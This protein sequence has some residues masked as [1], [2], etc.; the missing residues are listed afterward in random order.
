M[1]DITIIGAGI[2]GVNVALAL[3][4]KGFDTLIVDQ[5]EPA[6]GCSSG[7]A[8]VIASYGVTP[9]SMPGLWKQV[10]NML[11]KPDGPLSIR[12]QH[13]LRL[14]PW[15]Y[16]FW[17]CARP[18][19]VQRNSVAL[20]QLVQHG[21]QDYLQITQAAGI[22]HLLKPSPVLAVYGSQA[23]FE[24]DHQVWRLRQEQGVR[25]ETIQ[26]EALHDLEPALSDKLNFAV[27]LQN[28][29]FVVDPQLFTQALFN[30]YINKGGR[31]QR[32]KV[33]AL[34]PDE[35]GVTLVT[36]TDPLKAKQV[37]V[38]CGAFSA[39]LAQGLG[40]KIPLEQERG[41]HITLSDF[42]GLPPRH[43]IISPA[44]KVIATPMQPGLR[45]AGMVEFGGFLPPNFKRSLILHQ[46]LLALFPT[47]E[48]GSYTQ[49]MGHRPTLPDSV[50]VI[51]R[52]AASANI[53]YAFGH[54]HVGLTSGPM[55]ARLITEMIEGVE[56]T[57]DITP[58][59]ASRFSAF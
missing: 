49:W 37:V 16:R 2:I 25:W 35:C 54:Q 46:Q 31:Y 23:D 39:L 6:H 56:P 33:N 50:P 3:Q 32:L 8:G 15:L 17:R 1:A 52:S 41:Y 45:I 36:S 42:K 11:F 20:A 34:Q 43:A 7:N 53:F 18:D 29:G 38:A 51:D 26:E 5:N 24:R 19:I 14:L 13:L 28:T 47:I 57:V 59:R 55:T 27:M 12:R 10:P 4:K 40:E 48:K 22:G 44:H 21:L 30:E 58:Y 9:V